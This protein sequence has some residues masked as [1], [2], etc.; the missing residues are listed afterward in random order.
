MISM[1]TRST[2]GPAMD[3]ARDIRPRLDEIEALLHHDHYT[4]DEAAY[5]LGMNPE[6]LCQAAQRH[7]LKAYFVNHTIVDIHRDDLVSWLESR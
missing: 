1:A 4:V 7:E 6:V 3:Y 2:G 5:I